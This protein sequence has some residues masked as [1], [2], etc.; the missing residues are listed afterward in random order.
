VKKRITITNS[1]HFTSTLKR[2]ILY[3]QNFLGRSFTS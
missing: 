1:A 3:E 2:G